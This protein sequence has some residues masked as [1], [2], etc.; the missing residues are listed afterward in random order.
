MDN[1]IKFGYQFEIL[2]GYQ[3]ERGDLFYAY[4]N[5]Y[6]ELRNLYDKSHPMNLIAKLLMNSLYGKFGMKVV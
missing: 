6:Y 5:K 2:K 3:F 1:A 4:I